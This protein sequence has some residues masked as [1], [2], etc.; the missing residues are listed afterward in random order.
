[1]SGNDPC[2]QV[3][4]RG[5]AS[6][7]SYP[8]ATM[9]GRSHVSPQTVLARAVN[10]ER[11]YAGTHGGLERSRCS[12]NGLDPCP[13]KRLAPRRTAGGPRGNRDNLLRLRRP[14]RGD[15]VVQHRMV[16]SALIEHAVHHVLDLTGAEVDL[17]EVGPKAHPGVARRWRLQSD[18]RPTGIEV[19][20]CQKQRGQ[21]RAD[22]PAAV[23]PAGWKTESRATDARAI[24]AAMPKLVAAWRSRLGNPAWWTAHRR[25]TRRRRPPDRPALCCLRPTRPRSVC[26]RCSTVC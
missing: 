15:S 8:V 20:R 7:G 22:S 19:G 9:A 14:E 21:S 11:C 3:T 18:R 24:S 4:S 6:A 17:Q 12:H 2:I 10:R 16:R 5:L 1:M 23:A 25:R 13:A 26:W